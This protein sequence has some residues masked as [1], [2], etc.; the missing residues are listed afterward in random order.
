VITHVTSNLFS[1]LSNTPRAFFALHTHILDL[2]PVGTMD[3]DMNDLIACSYT[4]LDTGLKMVT[5]IVETLDHT[6]KH[7][8]YA[9]A[10]SY[11][12]V[13]RA[14]LCY[15]GRRGADGGVWFHEAEDRLRASMERYL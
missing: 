15:I 3:H 6:E 4:A 1:R 12:Y 10:P 2:P 5:D 11:L 14:A 13:V 8:F 7:T 9:V